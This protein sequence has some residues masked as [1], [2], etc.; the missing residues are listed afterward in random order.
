MC[1]STVSRL[2]PLYL[3]RRVDPT[4]IVYGHL[5]QSSILALFLFHCGALAPQCLELNTGFS[6]HIHRSNGSFGLILPPGLPLHLVYTFSPFL[7]W[8]TT[9]TTQ[10]QHTIAASCKDIALKHSFHGKHKLFSALSSA[11]MQT[12]RISFFL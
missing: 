6:L 11:V 10:A 12:G 7:H 3:L 5:C 9:F 1:L 4:R 2:L 8:S